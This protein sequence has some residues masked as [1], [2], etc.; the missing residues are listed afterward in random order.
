MTQYKEKAR[1]Q[2]Q[3]VGLGLFSYPVLMAADILLYQADKVPVGEDQ[4]EHLCL[5]RDIAERVNKTYKKT[6]PKKRNVFRMP[7]PLIGKEGARVM[8][9]TD[10]T[11]KMSKSAPNPDSRICFTDDPA[12]IKRK[13]KRCKT[14]V[15]M[16]MELGN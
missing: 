15:A 2:G 7:E 6:A 1:K 9:L 4:F 13:I 5:A 8:S 16:G 3:A 14:D 10:G 12:A 11:S